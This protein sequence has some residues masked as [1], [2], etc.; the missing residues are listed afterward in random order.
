MNDYRV[1]VVYCVTAETRAHI[2]I[3]I[4]YQRFPSFACCAFHCLLPV[5]GFI[6][7]FTFPIHVPPTH[8]T[9]TNREET[10]L[11]FGNNAQFVAPHLTHHERNTIVEQGIVGIRIMLNQIQY[12][13][14]IVKFRAG[15]L[16]FG[17]NC[18]RRFI[19]Q[20]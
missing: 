18:R 5:I 7:L 12:L 17:D 1:K 20:V 13:E 10:F 11:P 9:L 2:Y 4:D 14:A 6:V 16:G 15:L 19:I 8:T 3:Y